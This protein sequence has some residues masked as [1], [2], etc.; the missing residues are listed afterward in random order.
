MMVRVLA[1]VLLAGIL[2]PLVQPLPLPGGRSHD[3]RPTHV[4]AIALVAEGSCDHASSLCF[5]ASGC[6]TTPPALSPAGLTLP[7]PSAP[8]TR[9]G[10]RVTLVAGLLKAGPPTPPPNG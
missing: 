4:A 6:V 8:R 3:C 2:V 1:G 10:E 7:R 9:K 5:A